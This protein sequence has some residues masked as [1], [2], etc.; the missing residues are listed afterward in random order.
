VV[1]L[2]SD[3]FLVKLCLTEE[4]KSHKQRLHENYN[5]K[6]LCRYKMNLR[7]VALSVEHTASPGMCALEEAGME[8]VLL[9]HRE[10]FVQTKGCMEIT[11]NSFYVGTQ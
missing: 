11:V 7:D 10:K 9:L 2:A 5:Q 8:A 4:K 1:L 6:L 3:M